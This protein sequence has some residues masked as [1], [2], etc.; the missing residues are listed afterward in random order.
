MAR[1]PFTGR[2]GSTAWTW[3]R[4]C[5]GA[6]AQVNVANRYGVTP[7]TLA[8]INGS[9]QVVDLLLKAGA[10]RE[11]DRRRRRDRADARGADRSARGGA[12][13]C[14]AKGADVNASET[15]QGETALMWAAAED[16]PEVVRAAGE[17]R[18]G[19][20]RT[21]EDTGLPEGE[22]RRATMVVTALPKGGFT[23]LLLAATTGRV[24]RCRARW[25]KPAP[26]ST[27]RIPT[28]RRRSTWRS[29]TLTTMS[30]RCSSRKAPIPN[31]GDIASMTPLY[32]AIDMRHQEPLINRPLAKPSGRLLPLDVVKVLLEHGADP[33]ARLKTPL[34]MRQHNGGDPSLGEGATPLM[35]AAKV[36]DVTTM[37]VLLD[38][39]ADPN[40]RLRNQNTALMIA[41][42]RQGRN[43]GP[44]EATIAAM[45]L[46]IDKGADP[47]LVNENGET[48]LHIAVNRGDAL[49]RFLAENGTSLDIKDKFGRHAARRGDGSARRR[50]GWTG[51]RRGAAPAATRYC[52]REHGGAAQGVDEG[53]LMGRCL[54]VFLGALF[55][56]SC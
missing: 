47:N 4:R 24:R 2:R 48:A 20:E 8:A 42:S 39:G 3:C 55:V 10:D 7:L 31:V 53:P 33:N 51:P 17:E 23:A 37:A 52:T 36:S 45:K 15:W 40:L 29:S 41:A 56:S 44:E 46:L 34:L 16:H 35:R 49:V 12:V 50:R 25:P 13:C 5:S 43:V 28:G 32:A 18:R 11:H 26:I 38:K 9:A 27:R 54:V 6:S 21:L 19:S 14:I 22:G 1:R 30:P